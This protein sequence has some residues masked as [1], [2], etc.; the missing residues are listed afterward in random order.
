MTD[1]AT[2]ARDYTADSLASAE[3][4]PGVVLVGP[5]G[6]LAIGPPMPEGCV[7]RFLSRDD[8]PPPSAQPRVAEAVLGTPPRAGRAP[9]PRPPRA[10]PARGE[11]PPRRR[12]P[13]PAGPA[14][15]WRNA[16]R[17]TRAAVE[18]HHRSWC[19]GARA[20]ARG[21]RRR[22]PQG[23]LPATWCAAAISSR[24][25]VVKRAG[26]REDGRRPWCAPGRP[27]CPAI[28]HRPGPAGA[29]VRGRRRGRKRRSRSLRG[30]RAGGPPRGPHGAPSR[31][32]LSRLAPDEDGAAQRYEREVLD[33][34]HGDRPG[35]GP[36]YRQAPVDA[37][38]DRCAAA[39]EGHRTAPGP[40]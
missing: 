6:E 30:R 3:G 27:R 33:E 7:S 23:G 35:H 34:H 12:A 18:E 14:H 15:R 13:R 17:H 32:A 21:V 40:T 8:G 31:G 25:P 38:D 29:A 36:V 2:S 26:L 11:P 37:R 22:S 4:F 20:A 9:A 28:R 16:S 24:A 19:P 1:T 39:S 10:S 5:H